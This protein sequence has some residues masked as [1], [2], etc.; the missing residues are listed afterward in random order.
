MGEPLTI[1]RPVW[2]DPQ[3]ICSQNDYRITT[4]VVPSGAP[5]LLAKN[6]PSRWALGF[7]ANVI[8]GVGI[9]ACYSPDPDPT[10]F[11]FPYSTI[12]PWFTLLQ[13][14]PLVTTEWYAKDLSGAT[15]TVIELINS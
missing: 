9:Q 14:G 1:V 11:G 8:G 13:H 5:F 15:I 7:C 6:D 10:T 3:F 2:A 4:V 12:P